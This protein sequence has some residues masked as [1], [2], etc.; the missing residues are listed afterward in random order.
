MPKEEAA[1][2]HGASEGSEKNAAREGRD[3]GGHGTGIRTYTGA[4]FSQWNDDSQESLH[5]RNPELILDLLR[6]AGR[7]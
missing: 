4:D 3:C 7:P 5:I 2:P 6:R 1:G